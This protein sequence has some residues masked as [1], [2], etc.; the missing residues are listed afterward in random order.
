M[1]LSNGCYTLKYQENRKI[2]VRERESDKNIVFKT[3]KRGT[4]R[5]NNFE[6]EWHR[7]SNIK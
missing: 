1:V 4:D 3:S 7:E 6:V 5:E 2:N